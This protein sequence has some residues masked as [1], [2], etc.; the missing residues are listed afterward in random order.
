MIH[1]Y[2][3]MMALIRYKNSKIHKLLIPN[4]I[5]LNGLD[6]GLKRNYILPCHSCGVGL[7]FVLRLLVTFSWGLI[8]TMV[9]D[10]I[11]LGDF[12]RRP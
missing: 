6:F 11:E 2:Y 8:A 4:D 10:E 3:F 5:I 9:F 7:W 12:S 1:D